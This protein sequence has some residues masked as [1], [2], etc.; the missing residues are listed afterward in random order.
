MTG[1]S[2]SAWLFLLGA[3]VLEIIWAVGL[4][5]T[6]GFTKWIPSLIVIA[7]MAVSFWML[8]QAAKVI[9]IG[10]A[11]A[12]WGG[13][14]TAGT[15]LIGIFFLQEPAHG[16]RIFCISLILFGAAGLKIFSA[17]QN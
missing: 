12:V 17:P 4:K 5:Y 15:A 6:E 1:A 7:V 9:P 11:Y 8:A 3:G 14:G 13:I 2:V 16:F 10:T